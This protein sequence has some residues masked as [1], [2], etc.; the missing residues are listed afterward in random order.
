MAKRKSSQEAYNAIVS[1]LEE[2]M[3]ETIDKATTKARKDITKEA[4]RA[5][6]H[7]Y[8]TYGP[9][10]YRRGYHLL[11][12]YRGYEKIKS[13]YSETGIIFDSDLLSGKYASHSKYHKSGDTWKD[14]QSRNNKKN[15]GIPEPD[16]IMGA[17][18]EGIHP[19]YE[20]FWDDGAIVEVQENF[21][22]T[23]PSPYDMMCDYLDNYDISDYINATFTQVCS[24]YFF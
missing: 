11:S 6:T 21:K 20:V 7:Y 16:Y 10:F 22:Y 8:N 1:S 9:A 24:R 4:K 13:N 14:Y 3:E 12:S 17:M 5:V 23:K 15:N 2:I 19:I 18:L